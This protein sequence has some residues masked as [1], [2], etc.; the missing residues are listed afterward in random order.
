MKRNFTNRYI[1]LPLKAILLSMLIIFICASA[2]CGCVSAEEDVPDVNTW[3]ELKTNL[4]KD[5]VKQVNL[6][7]DITLTEDKT[8]EINKSIIIPNDVTLDLGGKEIIVTGG[9]SSSFC[10]RDGGKLTVKNGKITT[11]DKGYDYLF[12]VNNGTLI[13]DNECIIHVTNSTNGKAS[14]VIYVVGSSSDDPKHSTKVI[15]EN[16]AEVNGYTYG[17]AII[18]NGSAA[19]GVD[20]TINGKVTGNESGVILKKKSYGSGAITISGNV[21]K[22]SGNVPKITIGKNAILKGSTN[23]NG[24]GAIYAAGYADWTINGGTFFGDD[25]LS[26][27]SGNF[28]INGGTFTANG[29]YYDPAEECGSGSEPTGAAVSITDNPGYARAIEI[30]INNGTFISKNQSA[31]F[32]GLNDGATSNEGAIKSISITGGQFKTDNESLYPIHIMNLKGK[33]VSVTLKDKTPLY[34][35]LNLSAARWEKDAEGN[36]TVTL[37]EDIT[38]L[39]SINLTLIDDSKKATLELNDKKITLSDKKGNLIGWN[40]TSSTGN[41]IDLKQIDS[42]EFKGSKAYYPLF[43]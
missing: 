32:E 33:S 41:V 14:P 17:L 15:I 8:I 1:K 43:E 19:Y 29:E 6:V 31:F 38:N 27:K 20:I 42:T 16:G 21:K 34:P 2:F 35:N 40:S 3:D 23:N 5:A 26:I 12:D 22:T 7:R 13:I 28:T 36:W 9:G 10:I 25:V 37:K 30:T 11:D 39:E 4:T 18:N 24:G